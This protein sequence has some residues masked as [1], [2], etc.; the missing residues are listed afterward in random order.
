MPL[1]L[2]LENVTKFKNYVKSLPRIS[3]NEP[4]WIPGEKAHLT[5]KTRKRIG[6][7]IHK[8]ILEDLKEEGRKA[9]IEFNV[10]MLKETA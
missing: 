9:E 1:E 10:E 3:Q 7:P 2:F 6:I 5:M 8:K 4:V